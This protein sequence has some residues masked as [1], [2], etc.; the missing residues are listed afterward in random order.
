LQKKNNSVL[1]K[2]I[3]LIL[4]LLCQNK[5][6]SKN[7]ILD[8]LENPKLTNQFQQW[9]FITDQVMG[10]VST[11]KF[12]VDKVDGV[13]CYKMTGDVSTKNNGG[14]I[15]IRTKLNPEIKSKDYRGIYINVYGNEKSYNLH[16]RTGLTL[17]PWQY[18]SYTFFS[19][20]KWIEIKAPFI[21]FKKSNFYQPKSILGQNIKSVGL[22]AGFNDFKSDICL[23]EI[24]FY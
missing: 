14:F 12:I 18:Y 2:I 4:L 7:M 22:V 21:E 11:G 17:A 6:S 13:K 15:Q 16:L 8:Q 1:K 19:S 5:V 23:G 24:G 10:G 3:F 20:K 9:N